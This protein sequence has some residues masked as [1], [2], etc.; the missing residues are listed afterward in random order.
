M[1]HVA[2][3]LGTQQ[4]L[5]GV[6]DDFELWQ[7]HEAMG[8]HPAGSTVSRQTL[9]AMGCTFGELDAYWEDM[10]QLAELDRERWDRLD[11][12][13]EEALARQYNDAEPAQGPVGYRPQADHAPE[14]QQ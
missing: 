14:A 4:G 1:S 2:T 3:F 8:T 9:E 13:C 10:D 12:I 5:P 7:L 11:P 6:M